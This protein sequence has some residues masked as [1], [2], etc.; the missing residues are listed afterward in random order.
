MHF[1]NPVP[2]M[3][4]VE[5]IRGLATDEKTF[6]EIQELTK[7]LGKIGTVSGGFSRLHRQPHSAANDQ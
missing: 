1:M 2:V 3:K 6:S 5:F 4:L 7:T